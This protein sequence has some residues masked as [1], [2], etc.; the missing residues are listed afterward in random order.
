MTLNSPNKFTR[1]AND[2]IMYLMNRETQFLIKFK[3]EMNAP[4]YKKGK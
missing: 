2:Q 1:I 4:V 3:S